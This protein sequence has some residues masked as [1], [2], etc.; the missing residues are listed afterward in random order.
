MTGAHDNSYHLKYPAR[1]LA[2]QSSERHRSQ[3]VVGTNSRREQ[4]E[5][6]VLEYDA[7]LERLDSVRVLTHQN[8]I[9]DV[10]TC[11]DSSECLATVHSKGKYAA[12]SAVRTQSTLSS[13]NVH[14]YVKNWFSKVQ[15]LLRAVMSGSFSRL[16]QIPPVGPLR[17]GQPCLL[18][19][20]LVVCTVCRSNHCHDRVHLAVSCLPCSCSSR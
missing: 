3:F 8:E 2:T 10:S 13:S 16:N 9:W 1:A 11:P 19:S 12:E 5:L 15:R 7:D 6:H 18:F 17:Q 20:I 4:N 14:P